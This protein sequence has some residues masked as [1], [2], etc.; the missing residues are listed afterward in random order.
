[1]AENVN[2]NPTPI[3]RNSADVAIELLKIH[4]RLE[5]FAGPDDIEKA[6]ARYYALAATLKATRPE[7]LKQ[8]I[9][10][11]IKSKL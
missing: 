6:F 10:E 7:R 9:T 1:M 2:V 8:F 3:Q 11:D 4:T 5:G